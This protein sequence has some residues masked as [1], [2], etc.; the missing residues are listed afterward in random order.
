MHGFYIKNL[1]ISFGI[2]NKNN[3]LTTEFCV[4]LFLELIKIKLRK[5]LIVELFKRLSQKIGPRIYY[6][7]ISFWTR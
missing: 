3:C 7:F 1:I 5:S 6:A 4:N 2:K